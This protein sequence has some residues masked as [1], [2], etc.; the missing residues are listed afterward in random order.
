MSGAIYSDKEKAA[1][2]RH[3]EEVLNHEKNYLEDLRANESLPVSLQ[4]TV[5]NQPTTQPTNNSIIQFAADVCC[6]C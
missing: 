5:S 6:A 4:P 3:H 2:L 1:A